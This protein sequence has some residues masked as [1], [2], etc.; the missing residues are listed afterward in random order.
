MIFTDMEGDRFEVGEVR[1]EKVFF[2]AYDGENV[3]CS[4]FTPSDARAVAAEIIA[5]AD[6]IE[7]KESAEPMGSRLELTT[8][9]LA[10]LA[11]AIAYLPL[12]LRN[13]LNAALAK[14]IGEVLG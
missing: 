11:K 3:A 7:G 4:N 9:D 8:A 2:R 13:S 14:K 6:R 5:C 12:D 1:D 10:T